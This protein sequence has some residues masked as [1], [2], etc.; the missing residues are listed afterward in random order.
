MAKFMYSIKICLLEQQIQ[1]LLPGTI[2]TQQQVSQVT[3]F[4]IFATLVHSSWWMACSSAVDAPWHDLKLFQLLL[5]YKAFN[6][7]VSKSAILAFQR[8]FWYL[9]EEMVPLALFSSKVPIDDRRSLAD[10][11][12]AVKPVTE[13]TLPG[14]YF[15]AGYG[16]PRF[17]SNVNFDNSDR[18]GL[19]SKHWISIQSSWQKMLP[20]GQQVLLI[21]LQLSTFRL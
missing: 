13:M 14:H 4:V 12:L 6:P 5:K 17:P 18:F 3:D 11:L 19:H 7:V 10:R 8:H 21:K 1:L 2:T 9:T 15:G 20:P 16:K